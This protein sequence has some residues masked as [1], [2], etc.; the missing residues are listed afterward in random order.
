MPRSA[1]RAHFLNLRG[2]VALAVGLLVAGCGSET[3][4]L[5]PV[6]GKVYFKGEPLHAGLIVFV[7]DSSRGGGGRLACSQIQPDGGYV[8]RTGEKPGAVEGWYRITVAAV[9]ASPASLGNREGVPRS[10]L[11]GRYRDP[12]LSGLT[13]QVNGDRANTVN[14][15][16]E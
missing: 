12:D 9:E 6:R 4:E 5:A 15:N 10:L 11:P 16:L 2:A 8:L 3:T 1:R 14:F 13:C 7:P